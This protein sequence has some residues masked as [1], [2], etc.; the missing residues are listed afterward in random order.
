MF[1]EYVRVNYACAVVQIAEE[2]A[3]SMAAS[4]KYTAI[5]VAVT[6]SYFFASDPPIRY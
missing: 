4:G 5:H 6:S 1:F 3:A 2:C